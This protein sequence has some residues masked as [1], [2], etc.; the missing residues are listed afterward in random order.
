MEVDLGAHG[1]CSAHRQLRRNLLISGLVFVGA[2]ALALVPEAFDRPATR[3]ING[4]ANRSWLFDYLTEASSRYFTFS[5]VVLMAMIWYCWFE[6]RDTERRV[7]VFVGTLA[8]IGAGGISRI[9]QHTL[10]IH[11]RPHYDAAVGFQLP[12]NLEE[13]FNN[14]NSF[15][16]DHVTVFAG[17]TVVLYIARP[18][19]VTY[20]ILWTIVVESFRN[21]IGAHYPSDLIAGAGLGAFAVWASQMSWPISA[22]RKVMRWERPSP[23]LFYMVAFFLSFQ[24]ATLFNDIRQTLGA[25]R[26]HILGH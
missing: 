8:S 13:V 12:L 20:A 10:P 3:L 17:L 5:G 15:P 24:I 11:P 18:S 19:F 1:S 7:R 9:L 6:N 23:G 25:V 4:L 21:Y 16:S 14:W 26:D 22:G 2:F